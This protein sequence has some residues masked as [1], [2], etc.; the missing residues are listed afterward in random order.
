MFDVT[1]PH[2]GSADAANGNH[3]EECHY[4]CDHAEAALANAAWDLLHGDTDDNRAELYRLAW[5][6]L[7]GCA[8]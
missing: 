2:C 4:D 1:C 6:V 8:R 7:N 3:W 5:D